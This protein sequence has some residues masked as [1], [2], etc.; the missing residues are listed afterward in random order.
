MVPPQGLN[1]R[2][3]RRLAKEE[4][5]QVGLQGW[6]KSHPR[7]TQETETPKRAPR[8]AQETPKR[9]PRDTQETP[10]GRSREVRE[11]RVAV[12]VWACLHK[13]GWG[14][15]DPRSLILGA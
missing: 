9:R 12:P 7:L 10:K 1:R 15:W 6:A 3:A 5:H 11:Q 8:D 4:P 14:G 2:R 13:S